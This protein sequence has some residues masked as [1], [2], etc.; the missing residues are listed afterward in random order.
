M[1]VIL[2]VNCFSHDTA[3]CLSVDGMV[4]AMA[5]QE[6]FDRT[7]HSRAFPDEAIGFCL[8]H[9]G[10]SIAE[11]DIVAFAQRPWL[12]LARGVAD[13]V[14]RVA[15][16]R[17][18]AQ[19]YTDARLVAREIAFRRRWGF[20]GHV[21]HVGHHDAHAAS[22]F[23][24]SPFDTAAVLSIDRG[25]DYLCTTLRVG[26]GNR[27]RTIAQISNPDSIGEVYSA[28]TW[29]LGFAVNGDEGKVMGLAPYGTERYVKD[30]RSLLHLGENG[31][32]DVD[33]RWFRYQR[34][35]RPVSRRFLHRYGPPRAPESEITDRDKDLAYAVQSLTEEA[36]LHLARWL[37]GQS[38][39]RRLC[40][41]GGVALNSVMNDRLLREAGFDEI[42]VQ[43]ASSDAGN[44]LGAVLWI[45]HQVLGMPRRWVMSHPFLG[46]GSSDARLASAVEAARSRGLRNVTA[47]QTQ[48]PAADAARLLAE[49]KVVGW[50][51]GRAEVGPRALGA[52]SI[53][54]DPRRAEMRDVVNE[55]VKHREWFR[56]FAPSILDERG[57][58]YFV[59][60][61]PNPFMLLVER[62]RPERRR[63]IPAVT[64]VDGTGRLQS[65]TRTFNPLFYR[66]IESFERLTG[67][68]VVLNTSF[69][70][71]GEPMVNRPEEALADFDATEMDALVI[72]NQVLEKVAASQS[73]S[74][75]S[76]P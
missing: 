58:E 61:R 21:A 69:N 18:A 42:F 49:G 38:G 54:A 1:T 63:E 64:H 22:A 53:L 6:R 46:P 17:F 45:Q 41:S 30:F 2:G 31:R 25:G 71:R 26:T 66:L 44:A 27:L 8:D 4:V 32:V 56:P 48:D 7:C 43:P 76:R 20:R 62:V 15:P 67:V 34:E 52:R 51:Q 36:G 9:A 35:G 59:D 73:R 10:L 24:A 37:Q 14:R 47:R 60:Y 55:R 57:S 50:Y 19:V 40:L 33:F 16:K 39:A 29:Y 23:F 68:P 11:I 65:V 75:V 28:L 74:L 70:V 3:A 72:G 13:A 5:E 12:D